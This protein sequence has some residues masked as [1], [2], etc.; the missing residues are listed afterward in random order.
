MI[1]YYRVTCANFKWTSFEYR[2]ALEVMY[3]HIDVSKCLLEHRIVELTKEIKLTREADMQDNRPSAWV[4]AGFSR[5]QA[6]AWM[7]LNIS[8]EL[9]T[10][11]RSRG[12]TPDYVELMREVINAQNTETQI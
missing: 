3:D 12:W 6:T 1:K 7:A 4:D 10:R 8:P 5:F 11:C 2:M 9:A